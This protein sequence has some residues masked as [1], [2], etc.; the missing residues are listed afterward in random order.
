MSTS[1]VH[2]IPA[3]SHKDYEYKLILYK[4]RHCSEYYKFESSQEDDEDFIEMQVGSKLCLYGGKQAMRE[5]ITK[6]LTKRHIPLIVL[7][8][9]N[10][11][12]LLQFCHEQMELQ[13]EDYCAHPRNRYTRSVFEMA[14]VKG[15]TSML[16][17]L[18]DTL[19]FSHTPLL[20]LT[21]HTAVARAKEA[22][23]FFSVVLLEEMIA[24][25]NQY[26]IKKVK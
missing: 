13:M 6:G 9:Y 16:R 19:C 11:L 1:H 12:E 26:K 22:Q 25:M 20:S 24:K 7:A 23:Q 15:H 21:L 17:W 4:I 10:N 8:F 3:P 18:A 14:A 5:A 2:E